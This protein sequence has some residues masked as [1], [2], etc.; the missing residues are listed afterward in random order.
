MIGNRSAPIAGPELS[1]R[2]RSTSSIV[3]I[4]VRG[5]IDTT[6]MMEGTIRFGKK[7][8]ERGRGKGLR[9]VKLSTWS[10]SKDSWSEQSKVRSLGRFWKSVS[11]DRLEIGLLSWKRNKSKV[12]NSSGELKRSELSVKRKEL[13]QSHTVSYRCL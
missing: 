13:A 10:N 8:K 5:T 3:S 2:G 12:N 11:Y 9:D 7:F 4:G 6:E 1:E